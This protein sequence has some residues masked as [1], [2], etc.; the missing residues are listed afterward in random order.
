MQPNKPF[1]DPRVRLAMR[2][3]TD[4]EKTLEV[5]HA[6]LGRI[7]EHH[8]VAPIHPDYK[9]L[10]PFTRDVERAKKLLSEA[11]YPD[12]IDTEIVVKSDPPWEA[13]AVTAM[14]EQWKEANIRCRINL[15]PSSKFWEAWDK[16]PFGFTFW[17]HRPLG[18]MVLALAYRTG[19]PWNES[20]YSNKELDDLLTQAEAVVD[21]KSR[22]DI[23]GRIE[24]ILQEDGPIVQ[25]LWRSLFTY[26][27]KR[28]LGYK[29][30]PTRYIF[31]EELAL[32]A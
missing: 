12:G 28:V 3:A 9:K 22:S 32:K 19:V 13:T 4:P 15:V 23:I 8:H 5:A 16:V 2:L 31:G 6:K 27:D 29:Q 25:P 21:A 1:D 14:V 10:E 7:A 18:V 11:G 24:K 17:V 20:K 30:H 26:Y